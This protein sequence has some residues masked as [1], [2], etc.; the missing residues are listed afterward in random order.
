[1]QR[2]NILMSGM[3]LLL[4]G[5]VQAEEKWKVLLGDSDDL[6]AWNA[7]KD[8]WII[9]G[10][11]ELDSTNPRRLKAKPGKGV[12]VN[13]VKG[14]AGNMVTKEKFQDVELSF[15]FM[16]SKRSN[17]GIKLNGMY[18][19]QILDSHGV[20]QEKLTGSHCGGLYPR[21]ATK[22][23]YHT[24]DKGVPPSLNAAKPAGE[25]QNLHII[26]VSPRF[27]EAGKKIS[28]AR[29][30]KVIHNGKVIHENVEAKWPTG[31]VWNR[32]KELPRGPILLQA[33]HGPVAFR[34]VRVRPYNKTD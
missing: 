33:D 5:S 12:F 23:R 14:E 1:M 25:W 34:N 30:V 16:V 8:R 21:A 26:F 31:A 4:L 9:G 11:V 18:E 24:T 19:I 17:S 28:H 10:D 27:D 7:K 20:A 29:F 13:G 22:P 6:S 2:S 3:V 32:K 15:D